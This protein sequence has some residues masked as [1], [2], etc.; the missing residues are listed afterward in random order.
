[1]QILNKQRGIFVD[2]DRSVLEILSSQAAGAI[3]TAMLAEEVRLAAVAKTIGD[4]SHDIKN[5]ITPSK[6]GI[7]TLQQMLERLFAGLDRLRTEPPGPDLW[8]RIDALTRD[9][10]ECFPEFCQWV[11]DGTD[12]VEE[13]AREIAEAVKGVVSP[14]EFRPTR[15]VEVIERAVSHLQIPAQR[16]RV[17]VAVEP[18]SAVPVA[19]LD[20]KRIYNAVYNLV[21]NAIP[22][23]P[24]GGRVTVRVSAE[25]DE[26]RPDGGTLRIVVED[27]G[28]GMPEEVR[29][30]LFTDRAVSTKPG[31]TGLGT[32]I[33][34]DV[35]DMHHGTIAVASHPGRGSTFTIRLPIR[36]IVEG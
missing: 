6:G 16:G 20:R 15:V 32:K 36:Q 12:A 28:R 17:T 34:K 25:E 4:I 10:R 3:E 2:T 24:P 29:R 31:G 13:R 33:V 22:E 9:T 1:M 11:Y 21:S 14:P 5:M 35:V 23:T 7:E 19:D 30:F 8:D 27:T 18:E 26:G